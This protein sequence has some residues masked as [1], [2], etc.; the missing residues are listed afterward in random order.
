MKG[1]S[2]KNDFFSSSSSSIFLP[3]K[4]VKKSEKK[5]ESGPQKS[6]DDLTTDCPIVYQ[7]QRRHSLTDETEPI[8]LHINRL[9]RTEDS[10]VEVLKMLLF[11]PTRT[12]NFQPGW[13]DMSPRRGFNPPQIAAFR[14]QREI[15]PRQD[16]AIKLERRRPSLVE[17][18]TEGGK[19]N[20]AIFNLVSKIFWKHRL[21]IGLRNNF[22][23]F[24]FFS[25]R[26]R[27]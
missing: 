15:R 21:K 24:T 12:E 27:W 16:I 4:K 20:S 13:S 1:K 11:V 14:F 6:W 22:P 10:R 9:S 26:K 23:R 8:S 25:S 3:R 7:L 18:W 19:N 5:K 17:A 2:R